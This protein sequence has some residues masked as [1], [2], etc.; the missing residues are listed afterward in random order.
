MI[1]LKK[2]FLT[3]KLIVFA[4]LGVVVTYLGII[5]SSLYSWPFLSRFFYLILLPAYFIAGLISGNIHAPDVFIS[6]G[7]LFLMFLIV[8]A[9]FQWLFRFARRQ[10]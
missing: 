7:I 2:V 4:S 6:S 9:G 8:A 10:I 3:W 1:R 5:L